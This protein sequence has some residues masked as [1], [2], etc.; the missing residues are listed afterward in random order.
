[1]GY[2]I[3]EEIR[4]KL[5]D[6]WLRTFRN[7][8]MRIMGGFENGLDSCWEDWLYNI[9]CSCGF[10]EVVYATCKELDDYAIWEYYYDLES[11]YD[12]DLFGYKVIELLENKKFILKTRANMVSKM[13][14]IP[15]CDLVECEN[16]GHIFTKDMVHKMS[17]EEI[18][19]DEVIRF[20]EGRP[21]YLCMSCKDL[22][23]EEKHPEQKTWR[24]AIS[25]EVGKLWYGD[26]EEDE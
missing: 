19:A 9:E 2:I 14:N 6:N 3:P 15:F 25:D 11:I 22:K 24:Q 26:D 21:L 12:N 20:T 7:N 8:L 16:C 1:M 4:Q 23:D 10:V 18:M 5:D 17:E 13:L